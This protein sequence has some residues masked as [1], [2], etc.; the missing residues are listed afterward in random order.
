MQL[1]KFPIFAFFVTKKCEPKLVS[2]R[3]NR[4][5]NQHQSPQREIRIERT[6][7][8]LRGTRRTLLHEKKG[9][10]EDEV[11]HDRFIFAKKS[12]SAFVFATRFRRVLQRAVVGE[13]DGRSGGSG[14]IVVVETRE[15]VA[16]ETKFTVF[17]ER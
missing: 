1:F 6:R 9:R 10:K 5:N 7:T 15:R 2:P 12:P 17:E 3:S 14:S 16:S 13:L 4:R 8:E 11:G